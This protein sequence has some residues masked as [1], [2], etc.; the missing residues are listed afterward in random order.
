MLIKSTANICNTKL[1]R[2][3]VKFFVKD[4]HIRNN[5]LPNRLEILSLTFQKVHIESRNYGGHHSWKYD[6]LNRECS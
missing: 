1:A 5:T 4:R 2:T 6:G 3:S